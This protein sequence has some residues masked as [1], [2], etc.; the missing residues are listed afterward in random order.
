MYGAIARN[1]AAAVR[2][3]VSQDRSLL[4]AF[5][6]DDSWLHRAAMMG[7]VEIME[8]LVEAGS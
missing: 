7:R 8:V 4:D 6:L 5:F 2:R 3:L 1:D